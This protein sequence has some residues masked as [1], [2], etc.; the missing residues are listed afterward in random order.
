MARDEKYL[1]NMAREQK[2]LATPVLLYKHYIKFYYIYIKF[3]II[4]TCCVLPAHELH[5]AVGAVIVLATGVVAVVIQE[6][7]LVTNV[8]IVSSVAYVIADQNFVRSRHLAI[9]KNG[10]TFLFKK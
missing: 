8:D 2:S 6:E 9:L 10:R 3:Y 1:Q 7:A 5:I 4:T